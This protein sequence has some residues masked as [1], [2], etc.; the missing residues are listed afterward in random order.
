[1][2]DDRVF[3]NNNGNNN[4]TGGSSLHVLNV[5]DG[6]EYWS[7]EFTTQTANSTPA[8]T[9]NFVFAPSHDNRIYCLNRENG[10]QRWEF[11]VPNTPTVGD[12]IN[13]STVVND[14][15]VYFKSDSEIYALSVEEGEQLWSTDLMDREIPVREIS[16]AL[17]N[18]SI[19]V[20]G[21]RDITSINSKEGTVRWNISMDSAPRSPISI[22]SDIILLTTIDGGVLALDS[23]TGT[24]QWSFDLGYTPAFG[25]EPIIA[26]GKV[27]VGTDGGLH[28]LT[29][30]Q[31]L[32]TT[33]TQTS[34][35]AGGEVEGG[36]SQSGQ[37]NDTP[38][39]SPVT[40][41]T[42]GTASFEE[43]QGTNTVNNSQQ[44]SN[45]GAASVFQKFDESNNW[46]AVGGV[47]V[48][49]VATG[50]YAAYHRLSS[51]DDSGEN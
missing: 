23:T 40:E 41:S 3:I 36:D 26:N 49:L 21:F 29:G 46:R 20:V 50:I 2:T 34:A 28:T 27:L 51:S 37:T 42:V 18:E 8:V 9:D 6:S 17:A 7:F 12:S 33:S 22:T 1:V 35:P 43:Q 13:S 15:I 19:Y 44:S 14:G 10:T 48:A 32:T 38:S 39:E 45:R 24:Q 31:T 30:E 25:S 16:I 4:N 5:S 47:G 11:N